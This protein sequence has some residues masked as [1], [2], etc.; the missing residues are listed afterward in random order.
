MQYKKSYLKKLMHSR[1]RAAVALSLLLPFLGACIAD[2]RTDRLRA[3]QPDP[4]DVERGRELL[5]KARD[6]AGYRAYN[7]AD[8]IRLVYTDEWRGLGVALNWWPTTPQRVQ[9]FFVADSFSSRHE[10]LN[11]PARGEIRG[12]Q[13]W[14][15]Y[16]E[17]DGATIEDDHP[18]ILFYLPTLHYFLELPYRIN[19]APQIAYTRT[20]SW[21]G[22]TY[23]L[24]FA[25]WG[26]FELSSDRDQYE[27]W[28]ARSTG[29]IEIVH[30][31][32]RESIG[33]MSK[34]IS[35]TGQAKGTIHY[36]DFRDVAG[37]QIP[38]VQT[39]A[40]E[41]PLDTPLPL[42]KN[43]FHR[44]TIEEA[45]LEPEGAQGLLPYPELGPGGDYK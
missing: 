12:V 8:T 6:V 22:E 25:T 4:A 37:L 30:Y 32:V 23:D 13:N 39:V 7:S 26:G 34:L 40:L 33:V 44:L 42:D 16:R 3:G 17:Q 35:W 29:R 43:F 5:R 20:E 38:F 21:N 28:I 41:A 9:A 27:L 15:G 45:S 2:L 36:A 18:E 10:L 1:I 24:V 19:R 31:T 14:R 11:G